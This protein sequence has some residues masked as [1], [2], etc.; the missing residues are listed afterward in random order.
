MNPETRIMKKISIADGI[1]A[2]NLFS[3]LMG[4]NVEPQKDSS[5][6]MRKKS[7]TWMRDIMSE[8]FIE[9]TAD[10]KVL[11]QTIEKEMQRSYIDYSMSVIVGRALPDV[12]DGFKPVHRKILYAMHDM[13]MHY[14][15][16]YTNPR[17]WSE[18]Y[19]LSITLTAILR[20]DSMV[21]MVR[22]LFEISFGRRSG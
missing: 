10:G 12:R 14:N 21:R 4:S 6:N 5:S 9:E 8:N 17:K 11:N 19:W 15:R 2:D 3:V 18:K 22:F 16:S 1:A 20:Y 13:G 7:K